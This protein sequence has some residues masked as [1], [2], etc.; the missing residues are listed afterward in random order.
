MVYVTKFY[1]VER[2]VVCKKQSLQ[3]AQC[4]NYRSELCKGSIQPILTCYAQLGSNSRILG[5]L[6]W[7]LGPAS[8]SSQGFFSKRAMSLRRNG[9]LLLI[10]ELAFADKQTGR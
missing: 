6:G 7:E 8:S 3:E 10:L 9:Q 4:L 2:S 1:L 5:R